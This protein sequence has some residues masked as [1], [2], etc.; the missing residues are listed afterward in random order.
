MNWT[1]PQVAFQ[2]AVEQGVLSHTEGA[3]NYVGCF[4]YMGDDEQGRHLFKHSLWRTYLPPVQ[5][6]IAP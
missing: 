6:R 5:K 3:S 1:D 4:M 2:V